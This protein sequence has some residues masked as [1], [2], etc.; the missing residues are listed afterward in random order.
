METTM[1]LIAG[2]YLY[3]PGTP[4]LK[5]GAVAVR[6][7]R[8]V[9]VGTLSE[10]RAAYSAPIIEYSNCV[11]MPGMVNAHTHLELTHFP[12]WKVR[13]GLDYAPRSYVDWVIQVIKLRRGLSLEEVTHSVS[14]GVRL[15][16]EAGTT[17][18]GEIL[19]DLS[20]LPL[21]RDLCLSGRA[22]LEAI[23][24]DPQSCFQRRGEI[25]HA[26]TTFGDDRLTSGISPHAPHTLSGTFMREIKALA[27]AHGVPTMIHLAES[28]EELDF[29]YDSTGPIAE[30]LYPFAGWEAFLSPPR[31]MSPVAYID[32]LGLLGPQTTAVHCAHVTPADVCILR[33]RGVAVVLC[34]RS[35]ERLAVGSPPFMLFRGGGIPLA[36]G[37]DS[38]ASNDSLSLWDEVRFMY[39]QHPRLFS[40]DE[41]LTMATAGGAR[42]LH[43]QDRVGS[44]EHGKFADIQVVRTAAT[45]EPNLIPAILVE[46]SEL[47]AVY[48]AGELFSAS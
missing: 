7:G 6:D 16:Q 46:A 28:T 26:L 27:E 34:P 30:L 5:G 12:A 9:E 11:I 17:T 41:L 21:Y 1:K 38:L 44:L 42:A 45:F 15:S 48:H 31:R 39:E 37:T 22:Y 10:L 35:N 47:A 4:P 19:T 18:V 23:G 36:L 13:K 3:N 20:L 14:E 29:C 33:D 24:H 25:E 43:L 32:S 40:P 8:I 2:E